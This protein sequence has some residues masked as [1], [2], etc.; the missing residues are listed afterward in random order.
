[1]LL[2][3]AVKINT[4]MIFHQINVSHLEVVSQIYGGTLPEEWL[5]YGHFKC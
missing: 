2:N 4:P 1:M 5:S 3:N